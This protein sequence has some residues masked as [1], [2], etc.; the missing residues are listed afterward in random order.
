MLPVLRWVSFGIE[1]GLF[2]RR[3]AFCLVSKEGVV[4]GFEAG[5]LPHR[6]GSPFWHRGGSL[7]LAQGRF[8]ILA[9]GRVS[10]GI[11]VSLFL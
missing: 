5:L 2:S 8:F 10:F 9:Q 11:E 4:F 1:V 6:R 3:R 7:F